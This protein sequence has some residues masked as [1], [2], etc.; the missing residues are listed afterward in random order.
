MRYSVSGITLNNSEGLFWGMGHGRALVSE[1]KAILKCQGKLEW[2]WE[3]ERMSYAPHG[4]IHRAESSIHSLLLFSL[5]ETK[6]VWPA[7]LKVLLFWSQVELSLICH[8][9]TLEFEQT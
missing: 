9:A 5:Q 8:S 4:H 1:K 6:A 2:A 3:L 7:V